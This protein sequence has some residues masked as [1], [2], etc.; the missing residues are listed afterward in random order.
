[1]LPNHLAF[2]LRLFLKNPSF[3][4]LAVFTL[5]LG[6]G[7]VTSMFSVVDGVM[8]KGLPY[9]DSGRLVSIQ[10]RNLERDNYDR[11]VPLLDFLDW[12][13]QQ[14][15]F[16]SLTAFFPRAT[17][18]ITV[19][20]TPIRYSGSYLSPNFTATLQVEPILGAG[21]SPADENAAASEVRILISHAAW[22][23][24]FRGDPLVVGRTV[25]VNSKP[26]IIAGVM[27]P[28][29]N[30][31]FAED[32]WLPL[33][34]LAD[35]SNSVRRRYDYSFWVMGRLLPGKT[36][37]DVATELSGI[38]AR[39]AADYPDSHAGITSVN[40]RP[41]ADEFAPAEV[42]VILSVMLASV[43]LVLLIA[44]SNVANLLLARSAVRL[45]EIAIRSALGA[46]RR[47]LVVQLLTESM[48]IAFCGALGGL[49][50]ALWGV[51]AIENFMHSTPDRPPLFVTFQIDGRVLLFTT[52]ITL[53]AGLASGLLPALRASATDVGAVLKEN[54]RGATSL[55]IGVL[56]R[57]LVL[58]QIA[59]CCV[60]LIFTGLMVRTLIRVGSAD[61]G[62][63]T[64]SLMSV[65]LG[66]FPADYPGEAERLGF[67]RRVLEELSAQ[68]LIGHSALT[69]RLRFEES[70]GTEY[71]LEG[72]S[73]PED[74]PKPFVRWEAIS[75]GYFETLGVSLL[76][77][78]MFSSQLTVEDPAEIVVNASLAARL[79]SENP[80]P[81]LGRRL[82][83]NTAPDQ[84][85][86]WYTIVGV[87][88]DLLM[89]GSAPDNNPRT[90]TPAGLYRGL[91]D[92]VFS[93]NRFM[94]IVVR[95]AQP[96]SLREMPKIMRTAV[97]KVDPN[98]P[99]Y[100]VGTPR[101]LI[102]ASNRQIV[103]VVVLFSCF[104]L[105]A[106]LLAA[107]GLYGV[108]SFGVN[109]RRNEIGVR[110]ALGADSAAI[111]RLMMGQTSRHLAIGLAIGLVLA[112]LASPL[113]VEILVDVHPRDP[114]TF[115]FIPFFLSSV[116]LLACLVPALRAV[117]VHPMEALRYE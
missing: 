117:R 103:L 66:L 99:L 95:P 35:R 81:V 47:Q 27:P 51:D 60:L 74:S 49:L 6:I 59:L 96:S 2:T 43:F 14:T 70:Y 76:E 68:P 13:E 112:L 63:D 110:L 21:F 30:F 109:Q 79:Q 7:L 31:P 48:F 116:A 46:T 101:D 18:N 100:F 33:A 55:T 92:P 72:V 45:K 4:V 34:Q 62:F 106:L 97:Q 39:I 94:T 5:A 38:M 10:R 20:G 105:A 77:G 80:G 71:L 25:T 56:S 85:I 37:D 104:G 58:V 114:F 53:F 15:V 23:R 69:N 65:R 57:L 82:R 98:I 78:R 89:Q 9:P 83:F 11:N 93:E 22:Q 64:A 54:S 84:E 73:Y 111:I 52:G 88:P 40:V 86:R 61:F 102:D 24:D 26:G 29:F 3:S 28:G 12:Q 44:C 90:G 113:L 75:P 17:V 36:I 107:I 115:I 16:S 50:F 108:I 87:A 19:D 1:M 8:L 42:K 67:Y 41:L 32:A 91:Y